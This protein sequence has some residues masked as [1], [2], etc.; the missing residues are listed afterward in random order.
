MHCSGF[1]VHYNNR[2]LITFAKRLLIQQNNAT[3]I[4]RIKECTVVDSKFI[5]TIENELLY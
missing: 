1:E 3:G 4:H 5:T 2:K